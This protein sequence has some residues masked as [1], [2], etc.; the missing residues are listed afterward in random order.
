MDTHLPQA[1]VRE[2]ILASAHLR[3]SE[4]VPMEEI[5]AQYVFLHRMIHDSD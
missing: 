2:S 1:T 5:K 4:W 3:Q